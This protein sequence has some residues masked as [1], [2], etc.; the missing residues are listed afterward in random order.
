MTNYPEVQQKARAELDA[1]VGTGR[2][3]EFTDQPKL[4]YI[5]AIISELLRWQPV[6]PLGAHNH[7]EAR[8]TLTSIVISSTSS[9]HNDGR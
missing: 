2:L 4:P 9:L 6:L 1:V 5:N 3:P 7:A 8:A